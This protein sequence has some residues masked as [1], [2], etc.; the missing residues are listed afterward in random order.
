M[1]LSFQNVGRRWPNIRPSLVQGLILCYVTVHAGKRTS[2]ASV[3]QEYD[4]QTHN[5]WDYHANFPREEKTKSE[6]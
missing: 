2:I 6:T 5:D 1:F 3:T 4:V